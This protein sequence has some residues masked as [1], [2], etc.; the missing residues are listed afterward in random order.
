MGLFSVKQ[1]YHKRAEVGQFG[2]WTGVLARGG[3]RCLAGGIAAGF[4]TPIGSG[5]ARVPVFPIEPPYSC[6][7][8][9][10]LSHRRQGAMTS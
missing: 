2:G 8:P 4:A 7:Q 9:F 5:S 1:S 6:H 10:P 3:R